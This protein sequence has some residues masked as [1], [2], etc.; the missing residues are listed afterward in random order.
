MRVREPSR[1]RG[2]PERS[3]RHSEPAAPGRLT[4]TSPDGTGPVRIPGTFR[5]QRLL[6]LQRAVGNRAVTAMLAERHGRDDG[7]TH[8]GDRAHG[9]PEPAQRAAAGDHT[10]EEPVRPAAHAVLRSA[11]R[12]LEAPL[13]TEMEARLGADFSRV[14]LHTG[15]SAE[16]SAQELGARAY[17]SGEHVV[18]GSQGADKHTLAHELTHVIQ[19]RQGPVSGT[20]SGGGLRVSDPS[21]RFE[22]A[23][24]TNAKRVMAAPPPSVART[25]NDGHTDAAGSLS[26]SPRDTDGTGTPA[27]QRAVGF[28]FE[29]QW[30]VRR[31]EDDSEEK[32]AQRSR[33]RERLIDAKILASFLRPTSAYHQRLTEEERAQVAEGPARAQA[34]RDTWFGTDGLLTDAG[35]QRLAQLDVTPG[36]RAMLVQTLLWHAEVPEEPLAGENLG[37][38]RVDGLVV[39]GSKFDLTADAS[40]S[41]GSNLEW[42]TDPLTSL[43]EVGTVM[44]DVTAMA[45]YLDSRRDDPYVPSEEVTAGGGRPRP[46]L[47]IYPD[48]KPL[49]FAPQATLGARLEQLPKLVDYLENRRPMSMV[50]RLPVLGSGRVEGRRQAVTDLGGLGDLPAARIGADTAVTALLPRLGL[51]VP[52]S[53]T[54]ALT[55]LVMHLAAYLMQGQRIE[56]GANAKSIAGSVMART[57]FAHS[58]SLLPQELKGHFQADPDAFATLVLEAAGMAGR[59]GERVF[60]NEVERGLANDRTRT[61]VPL[62]RSTWLRALPSG[63]DLLKNW[64]HLTTDEQQMVDETGARAVHKSLGALGTQENLVGP[65]NEYQAVV[66][67]LRR[68]KQ[69]VPTARLKRLAVAVFTLVEQLNAR[70][71]L[72]YGK[73]R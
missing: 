59:G 47:R 37:K 26:R 48:G 61:T 1:D 10:D 42:I 17:T 33:E 25:G 41:G 19:Q 56:P 4:R 18:L 12:P 13:R 9:E 32:H 14:R 15:I 64:E 55:G 51:R 16:R 36:E 66:V 22:R 39:A 69:D 24:E 50:E 44:D 29:A 73:G 6:A 71:T 20:D 60:G 46:R 7:H 23:A 8:P 28:E 72:R 52:R 43:A 27:V 2:E 34:L 58:F 67:E 31:I 21:D 11:G 35:R 65:Q 30:N 70:R 49:S 68:M 54:K 62:T 63:T 3:A 45:G 53:G 40:P 5:P 57:D 38:G